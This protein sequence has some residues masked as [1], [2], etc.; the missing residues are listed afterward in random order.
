MS[1]ATSARTAR[2][3]PLGNGR[4]TSYRLLT[5]ETGS[6]RLVVLENV[7]LPGTPDGPYHYHS[8]ADNIYYVLAGAGRVVVAGVSHDVG[9][10]DTL[11]IPAGEPH[12]VANTGTDELRLIECKVPAE[13]D[14]IVVNQGEAGQDR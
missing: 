8:N 6:Q 5:P 4:G 10:G 9:P 1:Y 13:S 2:S 11:F 7:I 14:F 12:S 3:A